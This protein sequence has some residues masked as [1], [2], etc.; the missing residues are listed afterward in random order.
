V[1]HHTLAFI[2]SGGGCTPAWGGTIPLDENHYMDQITAMRNVGG[3]VVVSFG[4][5]AGIELAQVCGDVESLQAAYQSVIDHYDLDW[6]DFDI[7]GAAVADP[8]SIQLR[9]EAI[10]GLQAGNPDLKVAYCL[11]VLPSGL[12]QDGLNLLQN[13]V[14]NDVRI[15][16]VNVMAMDYGDA[17]AP[18]PD[19]RM[20][21]YAIQA[22]V[23]THTQMQALGIETAIGITPMIGQ[24]DVPSERFYLSDAELLN[25][26]ATSQEW[27]TLLSMWSS[28]RDNGGCPGQPW[29]SPVCSGL[30]QGAFDFA[31]TF[32]VFTE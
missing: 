19:G 2:I 23:S 20:G 29:A 17:E 6:V 24:N 10:A 14:D 22:A 11:P 27:V 30:E 5:A 18:D 9:N 28:N 25:T 31:N 3:N 26:W 13:A 4:G 16:I 15:D 7:E 12:T 32:K 21:E 8:P 1:K